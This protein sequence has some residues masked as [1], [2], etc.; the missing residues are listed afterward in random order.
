[1]TVWRFMRGLAG[2]ETGRWCRRCGEPIER[3]DPFGLS[4]GVCVPCRG[5]VGPR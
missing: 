5:G 1:M 2:L 3:S 4:E